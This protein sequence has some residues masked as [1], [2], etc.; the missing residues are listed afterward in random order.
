LL[1]TRLKLI[2]PPCAGAL[3]DWPFVITKSTTVVTVPGM[4]LVLLPGVVSVVPGGTLTKAL[5]V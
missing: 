3:L 5:L 4:L 1:I 2:V